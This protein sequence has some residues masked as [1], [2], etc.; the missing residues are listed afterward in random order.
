LGTGGNVSSST[1]TSRPARDH[2]ESKE[3]SAGGESAAEVRNVS[4]STSSGVRNKY[5]AEELNAKKVPDLRK[6]CADE[7]TL[8]SLEFVKEPWLFG[9]KAYLVGL[10][11]AIL[12]KPGADCERYVDTLPA[13]VIVQEGRELDIKGPKKRVYD[14]IYIYIYIYIY[15]LMSS[16]N[17]TLR[18]QRRGYCVCIYIMYVRM[19]VCMYIRMYVCMYV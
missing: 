8:G 13:S 19:Y 7:V 5:V 2:Q 11:S 16:A 1:S 4:S 18:A 14:N 12:S 10:L 9:K 15:M 3:G 6:M 17:W